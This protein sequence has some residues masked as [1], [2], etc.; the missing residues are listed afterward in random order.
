MLLENGHGQK[1]GG[2]PPPPLA[3]NGG[4][5]EVTLLPALER[6]NFYFIGQ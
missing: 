5:L 4:A 6:V 2:G 3:R 1:G